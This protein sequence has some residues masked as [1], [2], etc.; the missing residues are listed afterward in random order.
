MVS[1]ATAKRTTVA[2]AA[3]VEALVNHTLAPFVEGMEADR[4]PSAIWQHVYINQLAT[5]GMGSGA[6][7]ALSGLDMALWDIRGKAAGWPLYRLLGGDDRPITAYAG[8]VSLGYQP[9]A[10]L[11]AEVQ[12]MPPLGIHRGQTACRRLR[13]RRHRAGSR[14]A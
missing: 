6:T 13:R 1:S 2:A 8:G 3:A 4:R 7:C 11:V 14:R 9:P 10:D 12:Q 5:H